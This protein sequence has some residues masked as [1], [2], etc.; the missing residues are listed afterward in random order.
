MDTASHGNFNAIT[1]EPNLDHWSPLA[2]LNTL[3]R[4]IAF[5]RCFVTLTGSVTVALMLS[6]AVY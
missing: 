3:D 6:Q 2:I 1:G 4:P 5:H